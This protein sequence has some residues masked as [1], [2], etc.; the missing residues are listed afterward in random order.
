MTLTP[1]ASHAVRRCGGHVE[2][3]AGD[4]AHAVRVV[5]AAAQRLVRGAYLDGDFR[6]QQASSGGSG[7]S[8]TGAVVGIIFAL[9]FACCGGLLICCGWYKGWWCKK[10][11]YTYRD[12][13]SDDGF[14]INTIGRTNNTN[15]FL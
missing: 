6:H 5:G 12:D 13:L 9:L 2:R 7:G 15:D 1:R 10:S 11:Y 14:E 4:Q 8:N 3:G